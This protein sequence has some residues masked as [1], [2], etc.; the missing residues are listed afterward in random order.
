[1]LLPEIVSFAARKAPEAPALYYEDSVV[2]FAQLDANVR[3]LA[4]AL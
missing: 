1:M 4:N 3:R 2:T